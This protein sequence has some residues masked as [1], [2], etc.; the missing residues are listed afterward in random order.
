MKSEDKKIN[1]VYNLTYDDKF[2][3]LDLEA[4][5]LYLNTDIDECCISDIVYSIIY[6]NMIDKGVPK[7]ERKPIIIYINSPGG[8]V[9]D[10]Y[11]V[12]DAITTSITP[13]YTVNLAQ[14]ASMGFLIFIAGHKRYSMPHAEF[15]MHDGSTA[16]WDSTAKMRDR[17][18]FE[19]VQLEQMNKEFIMS[20][21]N[22]DDAKYNEK[23]RVEWYFLP[24]E[25]K[26]IGAVDYIV[27]KD[28]LIEDIL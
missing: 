3:K 21:I 14:C 19:T 16:G 8:S 2:S 22:I 10:G 23:Y 25:A 18:E 12:I 24:D 6:Y 27:G 28:C 7:E 20:R 17:M 9:V 13:V 15:L 4:R 1:E 5:H 26:E 11:G